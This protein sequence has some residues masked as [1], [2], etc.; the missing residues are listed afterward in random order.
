MNNLCPQKT[1]PLA[2]AMHWQSNS[3]LILMFCLKN[4]FNFIPSKWTSSQTSITSL[5]TNSQRQAPAR[6]E[7]GLP[8]RG[9][10]YKQRHL[11]CIGSVLAFNRQTNFFPHYTAHRRPKPV[12]HYFKTLLSC[13]VKY[14]NQRSVS[15]TSSDFPCMWY[16]CRITVLIINMLRRVILNHLFL[17]Y[18]Y[19][20]R[21]CLNSWLSGIHKAQQREIHLLLCNWH[22]CWKTFPDHISLQNFFF[23][24]WIL[25]SSNMICNKPVY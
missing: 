6:T 12:F 1:V 3:V 14:L 17:P 8:L 13:T 19:Q 7:P 4:S 9:I 24:P 16:C 10:L 22:G 5:S 21:P 18:G 2:E 11:E 23:F 20:N 15:A 25:A